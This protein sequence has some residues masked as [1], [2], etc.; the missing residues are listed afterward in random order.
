MYCAH[1]M[2]VMTSWILMGLAHYLTSLYIDKAFGHNEAEFRKMT[3]TREVLKMD[4]DH[5]ATTRI[6]AGMGV[7][8]AI[9]IC[10]IVLIHA[11]I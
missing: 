8:F 1:F 3:D 2:I 5:M 7:T 9:I 6:Q 11:A 10:L 4:A